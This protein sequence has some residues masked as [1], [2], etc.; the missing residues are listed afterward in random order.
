MIGLIDKMILEKWLRVNFNIQ[1]LT[2]N[3]ERKNKPAVD[4]KKI[5]EQAAKANDP[6]PRRGAHKDDRTDDCAEGRSQPCRD[7]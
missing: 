5:L 3:E 6:D 7:L 1:G 4:Y 2:P